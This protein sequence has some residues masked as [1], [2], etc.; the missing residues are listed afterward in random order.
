MRDVEAFWDESFR[1]GL[2]RLLDG[3]EAWLA[4]PRG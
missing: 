4:R 1:F 2:D 3:L